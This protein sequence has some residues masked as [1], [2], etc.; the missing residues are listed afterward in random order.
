M[1]AVLIICA[2]L[3]LG[4]SEQSE[5]PEDDDRA[6]YGHQE[7]MQ[8]KATDAASHAKHGRQPATDHGTYN[9]EYAGQNKTTAITP[10][11][12]ELCNHASDKTK[13]NPR[14]D[15]HT[16]ALLQIKRLRRKSSTRFA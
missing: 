1:R 3:S 16:D 15:T 5:Y 13:N 14:D 2:L 9:P 8:I 6:H 7:T 10:R 4:T 11:H 12:D